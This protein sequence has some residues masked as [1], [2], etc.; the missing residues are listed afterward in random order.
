MTS[1]IQPE[2]PS[3]ATQTRTSFLRRTAI[4]LGVGIGALT[5]PGVA[6]AA[7]THCC[8]NVGSSACDAN[9]FVCTDTCGNCCCM[10][11]TGGSCQDFNQCLC[12]EPC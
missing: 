2:L 4:L 1:E 12:T 11:L 9:Q 10:N 5:V 3:G 8:P 7:N 6:R